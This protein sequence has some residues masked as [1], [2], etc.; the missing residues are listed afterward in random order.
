MKKEKKV[1]SGKAARRK[2]AIVKAIKSMALP[3]I[4]CAII[5]AG[6]YFVVTFQAKDKE[7]KDIE[8]KGYD[9]GTDPI[10][11]E[12]D[13][14]KFTL[15]PVTTQFEIMVKETGKVWYS[16]PP[17][18]A[19]DAMALA[20]EKNKLQST[21]IMSFSKD[22]GLETVYNNFGYGVNNGLYEIETGSDFVKINYTLGDIEREYIIPPV[23]TATEFDEWLGKMAKTDAS[24]VKEYYK[25]YDI[26]KLG[27][28]DNKE[29][30]LAMYPIMETEVIYVLRDSANSKRRVTFEQLFAD[31]GYTMEDYEAHKA[32]AQSEM[33]TDKPIFNVSMVYRLEGDELVVEVPFS[34]MEYQEDTPIYT[35]SMLP[36]FGAGGV[37][38]EGFLM[39]PEGG[40]AIINFNNGKTSQNQ[41]YTN[42]YGRDYALVLE[43]LVNYP[44]A[45]FNAFGIA[46]GEDSFICMLEGGAPYAAIQ[47]DIAGKNHSYNFANA[48]YTVCY[49]EKY[50][51]GQIANSDIYVYI[52]DLPDETLSQ[53]YRFVD[54]NSYIDMAK[55]Y[56]DYLFDN[57]GDVLTANTDTSTPV[58]FEIVGAVDKVRQIL[59]I[60]TSMPLK[61]TTFDEAGQMI[62][63]LKNDGIDNMSVKLTGW[64]NGGVKQQM[65]T[66]VKPISSLG[67]KKDLEALVDT[68]K[69][70]G[71]D[72]YLEGIT[73][74]AHNSNIFDGFFSYA[75]AA[76]T[77]AKERAELFQ[78]SA[79]TYAAREGADSY[80]LLHTDLAHEMTDNLIKATTGYGTG[81]AFKDLGMDLS[82]DFYKKDVRSRQ[83]VMNDQVEKLKAVKAS[84]QNVM[85][86]F[87]NMYALPYSEVV[88]NMELDGNKH[89][90]LDANV[91]FL[92]TAIHGYI[93]YTGTPIN[94]TGNDVIEVLT[95]AEYGAGL[96]FTFM[97]ET[98]FALQK[99]LYTEYYGSDYATWHDRMLEIYTRY[100]SELGHTYNQQIVDHQ[101]FTEDVRCTTYEDGTKVYVN[102]GNKDYTTEDGLV[103]ANDYKVIR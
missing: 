41:Y 54:S 57:Y 6:V 101:V 98:A 18:A 93:N 96:H 2:A 83:S 37:A 63:E 79:V 29:E 84:G 11:L 100:N 48:V 12:N 73:Q 9:G 55:E 88:T 27:R 64:C 72:L 85:I 95:A 39:V 82:S 31:A 13:S 99:T 43:D 30:L 14:L 40:G 36:Y 90:I 66:K 34:E 35:I 58:T 5:V 97:R 52:E 61:L 94:I 102:Y 4:L 44:S 16:T 10:V 1:Q 60:P 74:Y 77:I 23:I 15:D 86:N 91:P 59:G 92:Q 62:T 24:K 46:N 56:Q 25:K 28:N 53:R 26:N 68:A 42:M 7:L 19:N 67:G 65:L 87:G 71:V 17:D 8:I 78:Y 89:T 45:S 81:V 51:V 70:L 69:N 103:P 21:L 32:L 38:D 49:R 22:T 47:A 33:T 75:D 20:A 3:V 50:D 80:W 76:K